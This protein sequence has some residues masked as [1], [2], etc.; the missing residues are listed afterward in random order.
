MI[1]IRANA[2]NY[3]INKYKYNNPSYLEIGVF[4]GGTFVNV[5]SNNKDGVDTEDYCLCKY[6]NY[7]MT[8]DE[9]FK[10]NKKTYDI[11]FI[12]GLH[13]AYQVSK[14][15]CNSINFLKPNG[16][17]LIDDVFPHNEYEQLPLDLSN[18][19]ANTGDVWKA[20]YNYFNQLVAISSDILF[21][22]HIDRG[23]LSFRI[24]NSLPLEL[25]SS[26]TKNNIIIDSTLPS[27]NNGIKKE[28]T[29][30]NYNRDFSDY[31]KKISQYVVQPE[32]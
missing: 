25:D 30:Y 8:S 15:I 22:D 16:V 5:N 1:S 32:L 28:W 27:E 24:K 7:K 3:V 21:F 31:F 6:V 13:T 23:M 14:D 18:K 26:G 29:K 2:I 10:N 9:F 19:G 20:I 12:D 11:I 17:I 4:N